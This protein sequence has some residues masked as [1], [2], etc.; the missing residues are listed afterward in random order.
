MTQPLS[1]E[2]ASHLRASRYVQRERPAASIPTRISVRRLASSTPPTQ[3]V[4]P[5]PAIALLLAL[6]GPLV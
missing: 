5:S 4:A 3:R 1:P 2:V 6:R